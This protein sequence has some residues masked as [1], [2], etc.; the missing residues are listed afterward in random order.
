MSFIQ[1]FY[2][3]IAHPEWVQPLRDEIE[4]AIQDE[5]AQAGGKLIWSKAL[6]ARFKK[7]DA[8]L[9]ETFRLNPLGDSKFSFRTL[10]VII[11]LTNHLLRSRNESRDFETL[12]VRRWDDGPSRLSRLS[13]NS[14][15]Q[16]QSFCLP[17]TS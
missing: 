1:A 12:Y 8:F 15:D 6:V 11:A 14:V 13:P 9:K 10:C 5:D 3:L 7:M 4:Q 17:R 2:E 16:S